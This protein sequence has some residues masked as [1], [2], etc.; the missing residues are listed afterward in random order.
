[1]ELAFKQLEK[2]DYK[3]AIQFAI[4]GMHFDWYTKNKLL[5]N[6]YGRYFWYLELNR[7]TQIIALYAD[8]ELAGVLLA[9]IKGKSKKHHS[10]SQKLYVKLFDFL[11]NAFVKD[12]KGGYDDTNDE[13]LSDYLKKH[14]P[15]G[16]IVF[17][18]ANPDLKIKG[19]GS[20]LLKEFERREQ[21]KE[22]FL[23]TDSGCT[24]QFYERRG[25]ERK[26][27]KD[28]VMKILNKEVD[29][30]CMLYSKIIQ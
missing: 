17:L 14:S 4:K 16:E 6:L 10:F 20:K 1:M 27:E 29:L 11:Q 22:V 3:K 9:D 19:I 24:Y 15:D 26:K 8:D 28:N 2:K 13:L 7:A 21:G 23:F 25:F 30:S 18:A 5:L 12:S